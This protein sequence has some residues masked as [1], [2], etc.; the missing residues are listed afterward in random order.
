MC[1]IVPGSLTVTVSAC[2]PI[3]GTYS[4]SGTIQI[5]NASTFQ[6]LVA[7]GTTCGGGGTSPYVVNGPFSSG[8]I[9]IPYTVTGILATAPL[10]CIVSAN[11]YNTST[12]TSIWCNSA[13][14]EFVAPEPCFTS[15]LYYEFTNCCTLDVL[16]FSPG[17]DKFFITIDE[18]T[19]LYTGPN[20]QGLESNTCYTV[21]NAFTTDPVFFGNLPLVP[22]NS[23]ANYTEAVDCNDTLVCPGC[24]VPCYRLYSCDGLIP[25]FNTYT[26]LSAY[27][28]E[29]VEV[30]LTEIGSPSLGCFYVQLTTTG[31]CADA[32]EV[33][34][35]SQ[36]CNCEC[37]CYTIIGEAKAV[38]Y[39]NCET[40]EINN[41]PLNLPELQICSQVYPVISGPIPGTIP[42][43]TSSGPCE[44]NLTTGEWDCPPECFVLTDCAGILDP[45]YATK[46]SLSPFAILGQ[47][48]VLDNYPGTCWEVA[49][50]VECDCAIDVVVLQSYEDCPTCLNAPKYKLINCDNETLIVYTSTDLSAYV[51][52]VITRLDCPG[53]WYI[54]EIQDIPSDVPITVDVVYVDCIECARD[55]YLLTDCTG[56][57]DPIITYTDLTQ[58]VGSVIKIK[59]C[60]ETCW[61]VATTVLPTNA[62]IVIPDIEYV[63]CPECLLTFPCVCTTVRND[64]ALTNTYS[65]YDC[66]LVVQTFMLAPGATSD[67][68]CMRVWANYFPET[69][70][71]E[72]FGNCTETTPNVWDCPPVIYPRRSVQPGYNTPACTIAKYEK[73]SCKSADVYYKQ[74]L[75]LRYG[76]TDCCPDEND[77]WVIKKELIDMDALRDPNYECTVV[78]SCCPSTPSCGYSPC[79]CSQ[80]ITTCNSQ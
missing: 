52:Q 26:D 40:G 33:E 72:T 25:P 49:D 28:G 22:A 38:F 42:V 15:F 59:Y 61:T 13:E 17:D 9:T 74:V 58:Y 1:N 2:D 20:Y 39:L 41:T 27:V 67:R 31:S 47:V 14:L 60:P 35:I 80:P 19:Y 34:V 48:V 76:I 37:T 66:E 54:E 36:D 24:D 70:Y 73:I 4:I 64:S 29:F 16:S 62:G 7:F 43:I 57:K 5:Y 69:D 23:T 51:G 8:T 79:N 21:A 30:S 18:G 46:P 10:G 44:I 71:I 68:F 12:G 75:Y 45:I 11:I 63:N 56:Y 77:K 53:C 50:T 6:G 55:Y 3:T 78:N 32:V 65:Y